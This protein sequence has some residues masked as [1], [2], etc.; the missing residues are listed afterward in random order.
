MHNL[1]CVGKLIDDEIKLLTDEEKIIAKQLKLES[2][3][4]SDNRKNDRQLK[5]ECDDFNDKQLMVSVYDNEKGLYK[6]CQHNFIIKMLSDFSLVC[7]GKLSI[8]DR[9]IAK[10]LGLK[11]E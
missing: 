10:E 11:T 2:D 6:E 9:K 7:I 5:L 8:D 1:V 4:S 3:D